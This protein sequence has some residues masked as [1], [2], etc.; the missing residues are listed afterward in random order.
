T[1][2]NFRLNKIVKKLLKIKTLQLYSVRL[3][4]P[5][6]GKNLVFQVEDGFLVPEEFKKN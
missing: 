6:N 2:G 5:I 3:A 1:H 4:V